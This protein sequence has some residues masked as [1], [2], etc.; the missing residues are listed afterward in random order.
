MRGRVDLII[1]GSYW[2]GA[3]AGSAAAILLLDQSLLS[4]SVGWR[5]A[6]LLGAI[7]GLGVLFVRRNVPESPRWLFIHGRE[8]EAERIVRAIEQ[9]VERETGEHLEEPEQ[10]ITVRQRES[11]PFREIAKTAFQRYPRRAVLG[12]ALFI[13]Q[14]FLYN[15]VT[16][17][18]GI[19]LHDVLQGLVELRPGLP[20]RLRGRELPRAAAARAA[21]RHRRA[22]ADDRG[23]LPRLGG[24]RGV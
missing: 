6:F 14:A 16:F 9:G 24:D 21:V 1:N 3:A 8:E 22:E 5:L 23:H 17:N 4:S 11:I 2:V 20:H 7:L 15:G 18:L 13:G 10:T 12:L 19:A